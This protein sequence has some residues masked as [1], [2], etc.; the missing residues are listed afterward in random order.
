VAP[1]APAV[2]VEAESEPVVEEVDPAAEVAPADA[3][4][5]TEIVD[6]A[7][8]EE[9]SEEASETTAAD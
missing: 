1:V 3:T 8:P 9:G 4:A 6:G 7:V 2:P 5:E